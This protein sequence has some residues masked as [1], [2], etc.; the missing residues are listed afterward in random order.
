RGGL[1]LWSIICRKVKESTINKQVRNLLNLVNKVLP[2][3][4]DTPKKQE[5]YREVARSSII[6]LKNDI[7]VLPLDP[8]AE[9]TYGLIIG[10]AIANPAVGGGGLANLISY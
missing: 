8:L 6:L 9:Q 5:V 3:L 10:P 7:N 2:A 4:K 1:L